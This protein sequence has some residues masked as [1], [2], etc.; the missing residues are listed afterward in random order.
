MK[1]T[2]LLGFDGEA[3]ELFINQGKAGL[4]FEPENEEELVNKINQLNNNRNELILFGENGRNYVQEF[5]NR[6]KIAKEFT[7]ELVSLNN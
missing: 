2:L 7:N 1:K 4:Y 6:N 3:R 5:F